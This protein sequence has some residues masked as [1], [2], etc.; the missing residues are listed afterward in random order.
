MPENIIKDSLAIKSHQIIHQPKS[1]IKTA[2]FKA[3][4]QS[5]H[6]KYLEYYSSKKKNRQ[7]NNSSTYNTRAEDSSKQKE[8]KL[9]KLE[10]NYN[11]R[12]I[13]ERARLRAESEE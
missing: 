1:L 11:N 12:I 9:V 2:P 13:I 8:N 6:K 3:S 4:Q 7:N 5:K 10:E